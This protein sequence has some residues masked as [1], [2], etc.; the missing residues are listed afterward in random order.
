LSWHRLGSSLRRGNHRAFFKVSSHALQ[1]YGIEHRFV[2][3]DSTTF[4]LHGA[5]E[6]EE[7]AEEQPEVV[8]I[9]KG[10]SKD[11][12]P[13][14]NQVVLSMMT[15]NGS[16]IPVWLEA[17]TGNSNDK[18]SFRKS[19]KEYRKQFKE[20]E[21][22]Y[23]VADSALYTKETVTELEGVKVVAGVLAKGLRAREYHLR[24]KPTL[25]HPHLRYRAET[26]LR[27]EKTP[28]SRR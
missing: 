4:S 12:A 5:Y 18:V 19:I 23:F 25:L 13:D 15:T 10:Y 8:S 16:S 3:L 21:L 7:G 27:Q 11:N 1:K 28:G 22:P 6:R 14:L 2:H 17:L 20:K 26:P 24:E 9:T